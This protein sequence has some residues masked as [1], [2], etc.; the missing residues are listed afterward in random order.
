MNLYKAVKLCCPPIVLNVLKKL[1][2]RR[3]LSEMYSIDGMNLDL[4]KNHK[5]PQYQKEFAMYDRINPCLAYFSMEG[6]IIDIGANVGDT[7]IAML[8][9]T[10][11]RFL[12]IEPNNEFYGLLKKNIESLPRDLS[13]RVTIQKV[14]ISRIAG[15][16]YTM[17]QHHGTAHKVL[18][19]HDSDSESITLKECIDRVNISYP[20]IKLIKVDT[21]GYDFECIM[22]MGDVLED[23]SPL[24]YWENELR[25]EESFIGYKNLNSYL[26]KYG[27]NNFFMFDNFGNYLCEG[28]NNTLRDMNNYL[29][30][31]VRCK[32]GKTFYYLDILSCKDDKLESM[33]KM[34]RQYTGQFVKEDI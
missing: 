14:F 6:V 1:V 19:D 34:I 15:E 33:R 2:F 29:N 21:D 12:C 25:G 31:L 13:N 16:N 22:S 4:G 9:H 30:R 24:L 27:Y 28:D 20:E 8:K 18:S 10:D 23:I 3:T 26:E 32:T 7:V 5:L 11:S 17:D